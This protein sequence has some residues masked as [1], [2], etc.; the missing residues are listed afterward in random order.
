A[1]YCRWGNQGVHAQRCPR[2]PWGAGTAGVEPRL[3]DL[4]RKVSIEGRLDR[5]GRRIQGFLNVSVRAEDPL[6]TLRQFAVTAGDEYAGEVLA[7][8][9]FELLDG[10]LEQRVLFVV[11]AHVGVRAYGQ[12]PGAGRELGGVLG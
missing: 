9:E 8:G 12:I 4:A 5:F 10:Y 3:F 2:P 6:Q 1:T 7:P 11:V